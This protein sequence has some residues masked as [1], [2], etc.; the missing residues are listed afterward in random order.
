MVVEVL[1]GTWGSDVDAEKSVALFSSVPIADGETATT[2]VKVAAWVGA[3]VAIVQVI[4]SP[5]RAQ[6]KGGPL[7]CVALTKVVFKGRRSSSETF[8]A[9]DGP[10]LLALI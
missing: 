4:V 10:L 7:F 9:V 1:F 2:K 8:T 5:T 3:S 6:V